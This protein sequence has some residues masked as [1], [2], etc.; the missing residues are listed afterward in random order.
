MP[1]SSY[2]ELVK[3]LHFDQFVLDRGRREL[4][5]GRALVHLSPKAYHLLEMLVDAAPDAVSRDVLYQGLC[6]DTFVD[7]ANLPNLVKELR[8]ALGDDSRQ[9]RFIRTL[10]GFG[11]A[12]NEVPR[13]ESSGAGWSPFA[14][15]WAS[16]EFPLR[17]GRNVIGRDPGCD[18]RVD[19]S[20]VSR[21]H[22]V[23]TAESGAV[24]IDDLGSKN[25]TFVDDRP[26]AGVTSLADGSTV[27]LGTAT[28]R[29]RAITASE[30]TMTV[31]DLM[32]GC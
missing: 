22:A 17:V 2:T 6:P 11:Y 24:T 5:Q 8:K 12:F 21:Q 3:R 16:R 27:R 1:P 4:L 18:V 20:G 9:P 28:L 26:I 30:T 32:Q 14:L 15:Q 10:H 31:A 13:P 7:E 25:G 29:L 23:I 19:S